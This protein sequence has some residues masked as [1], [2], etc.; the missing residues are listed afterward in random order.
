MPR[1]QKVLNMR[2]CLNN[3]WI[4]QKMPEAEPKI[5]VQAKQHL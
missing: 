5:T 4:C 3:A 1:I 2:E